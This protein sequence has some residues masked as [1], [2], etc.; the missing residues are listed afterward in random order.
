MR[1]V[2]LSICSLFVILAACPTASAQNFIQDYLA[3]D[4]QFYAPE[5][6]HERGWIYR[7][8]AGYTGLFRDCDDDAARRNSPYIYWRQR[9]APACRRPSIRVLPNVAQQVDEGI[10]FVADGAGRCARPGECDGRY[11]RLV[12]TII[13]GI[14]GRE[15]AVSLG[16]LPPESFTISESYIV[17]IDPAGAPGT[18]TELP[19]SAPSI[20]EPDMVPRIEQGLEPGLEQGALNSGR[21]ERVSSRS[22][23]AARTVRRTAMRS[24]SS[25]EPVI[26][27]ANRIELTDPNRSSRR[28]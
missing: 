11:A 13:T 23:D 15:S 10:Q 7:V 24:A 28:R 2:T 4:T 25:S 27:T 22:A 26:N 20:L 3:R 14:P 1:L 16:Q 19:E 17:P 18:P 21:G 6:F 9:E 8:Q 5:D 12:P